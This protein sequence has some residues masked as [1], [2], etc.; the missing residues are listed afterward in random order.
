MFDWCDRDNSRDS[1]RRRVVS[2]GCALELSSEAFSN[3]AVVETVAA[4]VSVESA[5]RKTGSCEL[6]GP[7]TSLAF[8]MT[9]RCSDGQV[10]C[11]LSDFL[12]CVRRSR[13]S[14]A[15]IE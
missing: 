1:I 7:A 11:V 8:L 9:E 2:N 6:D 4:R 14:C 5:M 3:R 10:R 15:T 13:V 12:S